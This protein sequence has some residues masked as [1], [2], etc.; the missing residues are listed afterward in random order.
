MGSN[1]KEI[2]SGAPLATASPVGDNDTAKR[3]LLRGIYP[4]KEVDYAFLV[5][6]GEEVTVA[7]VGRVT[8]CRGGK[9]DI[10]VTDR[11][12][13]FSTMEISKK[14]LPELGYGGRLYKG[15]R[16]VAVEVQTAG[17]LEQRIHAEEEQGISFNLTQEE[18]ARVDKHLDDY[19]KR[20]FGEPG[21]K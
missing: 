18:L 16:I 4:I 7:Y 20:L 11:D 3:N 12:N 17:G 8:S 14:R 2:S 1:G 10:L 15:M 19:M 21:A 13:N 5:K 9:I 6:P